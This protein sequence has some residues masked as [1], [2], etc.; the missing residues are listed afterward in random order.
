MLIYADRHL[1]GGALTGTLLAVAGCSILTLTLAQTLLSE[2][3]IKHFN[4]K[5]LR[6]I[7]LLNHFQ[8]FLSSFQVF[9]EIS[10]LNFFRVEKIQSRRNRA[11]ERDGL[12]CWEGRVWNSWCRTTQEY[13][14][15]L[16]THRH[17]ELHSDI[18]RSLNNPLRNDHLRRL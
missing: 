8:Y 2:S 10:L 13:R 3:E 4:K 7:F 14:D 6:R 9:P 17:I 12:T 18:H 15:I 5:I 1:P 11:T 16:Q